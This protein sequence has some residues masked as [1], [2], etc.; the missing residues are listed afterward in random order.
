[1]T[2]FCLAPVVGLTLGIIIQCIK[3][4]AESN[5]DHI[6]GDKVRR[7]VLSIEGPTFEARAKDL[8]SKNAVDP[9]PS[10]GSLAGPPS[11]LQIAINRGCAENNGTIDISKVLVSSS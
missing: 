10:N 7:A 6:G 5:R 8:C 2:Y 4:E 3:G 9:V 1:M 11:C